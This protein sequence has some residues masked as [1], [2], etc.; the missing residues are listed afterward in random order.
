LLTVGHSNHT[1]ERLLSLLA[2]HRVQ[3]LVDVRSAPYAR[4]ATQFNR[5]Q[6]QPAVTAAGLTYLFMGEELGGRQL[7]G[8]IS[9]DKRLEKYAEVAAAPGFR[10]GIERLLKG[11]QTYRIA[12]LC[13]EEDPTECHRRIWVTQALLDAGADVAHLRG[14][15]R[16]DADSAL[17]Q[18]E[19]YQLDLFEG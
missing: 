9:K 15:G 5:E 7:G 3:V 18:H 6:L 14:D 11:A 19:G 10:R 4:Y 1:V 2:E 13:A 17:K 8:I 12:L 16:V